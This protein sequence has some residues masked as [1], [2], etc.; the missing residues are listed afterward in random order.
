MT[1]ENHTERQQPAI[2][3]NS[4]VGYAGLVPVHTILNELRTLLSLEKKTPK[5][6]REVTYFLAVKDMELK[7][8]W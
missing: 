3:K 5:P 7:R 1:T 2:P 4:D 8:F 6:A